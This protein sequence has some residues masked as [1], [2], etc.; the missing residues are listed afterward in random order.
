M[1]ETCPIPAHYRFTWPGDVERVVCAAHA[2]QLQS[3]AAHMGC[4]LQMIPVDF[5]EAVLCTQPLSKSE[6]EAIAKVS[7]A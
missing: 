2:M 1:S 3:L 4:P 5:D 7:E 6:R